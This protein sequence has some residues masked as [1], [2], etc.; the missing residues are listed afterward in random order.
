[1]NILLNQDQELRSGWK[2]VSYWV[3]FVIFLIAISALIPFGAS[4]E[5]QT[6]RLVLNT[7]PLFPAIGALLI[8]ARFADRVPIGV[9]GVTFHERWARD[10]NVGIAVG[11]GM[12]VALTLVNGAAGGITMEWSASDASNRSLL[13]TP[14][15][16]ILSAAQE[17]LVFRG[18]PL[19]V[20]MKGIGVWPAI[21]TMSTTFGLVHL[22][23]PNAT[24]VGAVN[25]M[26]AGL[27][28]SIAYLKT[29]SLW[30]PYGLHLGWNVGL[31]F[32]L[33]YPL[34]GIKIDSLWTTIAYG[35]Q[36]LVGRAY[37]PEGGIIGTIVFAAAAMVIHKMRG[38]GISPRIRSLLARNAS[39][40]QV[41]ENRA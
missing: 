5:T 14:M 2:F 6:Q 11:T 1:M 25:T 23:N 9:F 40:V 8:M 21:L 19:Q 27:M 34:S 31:G 18:Y 41:S 26:L 3:L 29:R 22:L 12:L 32:V 13:I 4:P 35:P 20:L 28:L 36:W 37:G 38:V 15:V 24:I 16:L 39:E 10:L 30:M 17:E 33:G 7:I